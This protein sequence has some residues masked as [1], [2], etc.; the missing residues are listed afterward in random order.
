MVAALLLNSEFVIDKGI[1]SMGNKHSEK[2]EERERKS[3]FGGGVY[4]KKKQKQQRTSFFTDH[5][6]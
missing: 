4:R 2:G 3:L 1:D 6:K 5:L